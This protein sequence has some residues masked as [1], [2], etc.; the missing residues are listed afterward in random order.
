MKFKKKED[1]RV[2]TLVLL[3]REDKISMEG[4]TETKCR[5]E[6]GG[7]AIQRLPLLGIYPICSSYQ[8]QKQLFMPTSAC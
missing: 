3:R 5:A 8:T 2:D 1:Q 7:K 6:I 4:D